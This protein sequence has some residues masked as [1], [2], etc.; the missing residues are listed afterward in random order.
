MRGARTSRPR[1]PLTA[2]VGFTEEDYIG[3]FDEKPFSPTVAGAGS[4]Q[5][6]AKQEGD[7]DAESK[8][9]AAVAAEP[10]PGSRAEDYSGGLG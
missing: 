3:L 7:A 10:A 4:S 2:Q 6:G 5:V 9:Q 8:A 1:L